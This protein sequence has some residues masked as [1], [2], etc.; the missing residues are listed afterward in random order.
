VA[1]HPGDHF[2]EDDDGLG[3]LVG[4]VIVAGTPEAVSDLL[5]HRTRVV[6]SVGVAHQAHL[7]GLLGER[8]VGLADVGTAPDRV[9]EVDEAV[10]RTDI[11][12]P[13]D[14]RDRRVAVEDDVVRA[15]VPVRDA[16]L[17]PR[18]AQFRRWRRGSD[19]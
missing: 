17:W 6:T 15:E 12:V 18:R 4:G 8:D 1:L 9:R 10:A 5:D 19:E 2:V 11:V 14:D 16:L 13:V 7:A 3:A